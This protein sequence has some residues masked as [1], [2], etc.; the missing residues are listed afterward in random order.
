ML[1]IPN[2]YRDRAFLFKQVHPASSIQWWEAG[3][4]DQDSN[5]Y[6]IYFCSDSIN[7]I[8]KNKFTVYNTYISNYYHSFL[9][10]DYLIYKTN[11]DDVVYV[12][13]VEGIPFF[14][15][16]IDNLAEAL[17]LASIYGYSFIPGMEYGSYIFQNGSYI[18]NLYKIV[19]PPDV[20]PTTYIDEYGHVTY[21]K[22]K[23]GG[24]CTGVQILHLALPG[25]QSNVKT[26]L[27]IVYVDI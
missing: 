13:K 4:G 26:S 15:G 7:K 27:S 12:D 5:Q 17:L 22:P 2:E 16:N 21:E 19:L 14:I 10:F 24:G 1:L 9:S 23:L 25:M 6:E 3:R 18:L 20:M 8:N 11:S